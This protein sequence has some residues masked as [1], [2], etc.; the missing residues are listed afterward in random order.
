M[1]YLRIKIKP[2][3][4]FGTEPS[5]DTLFGQLCYTLSLMNE[6]MDNL[7]GNYSSEPF[8]V[9]SD[10]LPMGY[11]LKPQLPA[12]PDTQ[13]NINKLSERKKLKNKNRLL[14]DDVIKTSCIENVVEAKWNTKLVD[15]NH[16]HI[17]RLSG[18]S[19]SGAFSPYKD[20]VYYYTSNDDSDFFFHLYMYVKDEFKNKVLDALNLMGKSGYGKKTSIGKGRFEVGNIETI[21]INVSGKNSLFTLGNCVISNHNNLA[22]NIYYTPVVRFGKHGVASSNGIP[23]KSPF[24]MTNQGAV[25]INIKDDTIFRKPYIGNAVTNISYQSNTISQ[26]YSLYIPFNY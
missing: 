2:L 9:L 18:F 25:F 13:I 5:S 11:A 6:D 3:T 21:N 16:V 7:L 17:D 26:G 19:G 14:V 12:Q 1:E 20:M 4:A 10:F 8:A 24:V 23:F 15:I 22:E